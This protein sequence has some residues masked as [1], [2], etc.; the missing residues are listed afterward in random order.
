MSNATVT[1]VLA[2][3]QRLAAVHRLVPLHR[4]PMPTFD[5]LTRLAAELLKAPIALLSLLEDDR[6]FFVSSHGLP[7]EVRSARQTPLDYS[8]CQH[9]VA[10]GRPLATW[11]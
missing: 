5:R 11:R 7:E 9:T 6:Q 3:R 1:E 10:A 4:P 8:I 2:D